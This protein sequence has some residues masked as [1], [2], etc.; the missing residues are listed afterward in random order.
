[1]ITKYAY[2]SIQT[3]DIETTTNFYC[4][5]LGFQPYKK[6]FIGEGEEQVILQFIKLGEAML[7]IFKLPGDFIPCDGTFAMIGIYVEDVKKAIKELRMK[8]VTIVDDEPWEGWEAGIMI[9]GIL[10]PNKEKIMLVQNNNGQENF[11]R[12][13]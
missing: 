8:G 6:V 10:G 3:N 9:A 7:E 12:E 5:L 11:S 4:E 1:M 13:R 2:T